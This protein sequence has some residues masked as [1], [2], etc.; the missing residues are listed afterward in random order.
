M[1]IEDKQVSGY[2]V[3]NDQSGEPC[4]VMALNFEEPIIGTELVLTR[5][6]ILYMLDALNGAW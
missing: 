1:D 4:V 5:N 2:E 6:D 3:L